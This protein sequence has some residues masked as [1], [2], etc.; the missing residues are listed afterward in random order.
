METQLFEWDEWDNGCNG[1]YFFIGIT[2]SVPLGNIPVGTK[3]KSAFVSFTDG[4]MELYR[5]D[6]TSVKFNLS[7]VATPA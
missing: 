1:E 4:Y 3:F 6:G 7:L 2:T 5:E